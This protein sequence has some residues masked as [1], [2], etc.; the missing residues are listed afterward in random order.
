M[1]ESLKTYVIHVKTAYEREEHMKIQLEGRGLDYEFVLD[2]D[3]PDLNQE[4]VSQYF[5]ENRYELVPLVSCDFKHIQCCEYMVRDNIPMALILE[6][7][8]FFYGNWDNQFPLIMKEIEERNLSSFLVSLEDSSLKYPEG[9]KRN[10]G[11]L[12]YQKDSG[13]NCGAYLVDIGYAKAILEHIRHTRVFIPFGHYQNVVSRTG[14]FN[15]YWAEP[16]V[17]VQGTAIGKFETTV[18]RNK[19]GLIGRLSWLLQ[20]TYKRLL[21]R[22]R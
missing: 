21:Y 2:G 13:R 4:R 1:N 19:T 16:T 6:D 8:M 14:A 12:L 18:S 7:D 15:I 17:I 9:S 10:K 20:R 11:Q 22:L 5:A 3:L